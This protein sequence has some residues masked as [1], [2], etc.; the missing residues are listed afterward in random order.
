M[1]TTKTTRVFTNGNSQAVRIPREYRLRTALVQISE[2]ED[3]DLV[4]HP[5][6][7][8]PK[9]RE[10]HLIEILNR[11]DAADIAAFEEAHRDQGVVQERDIL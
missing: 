6:A 2:N 11:L 4:L 10:A 7:D 8:E 5:I 3:G 9:E 1:A